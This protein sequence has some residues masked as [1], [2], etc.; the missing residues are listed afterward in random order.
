MVRKSLKREGIKVATGFPIGRVRQDGAG[1]G[2]Q[3]GVK[4]YPRVI[5]CI[6]MAKHHFQEV[7]NLATVAVLDC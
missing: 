4:S 5:C 7:R 1:W 6:A 3:M 2:P